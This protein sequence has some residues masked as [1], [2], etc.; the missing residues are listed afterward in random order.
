MTNTI[1]RCCSLVFL[2]ASAAVAAEPIDVGTRLEPVVDDYLIARLDGVA[3]RLHPPIPREIVLKLDRPWEGRY[4]GYF[5]VLTEKGTGPIC[6][7]GPKGAA[8]K[9]DLSPFPAYRMYYRGL[10]NAGRG[11]KPEE[12]TCCAESN[13]GVHWTRPNLGLYE[14]HGTKENNVMLA[15]HQA[16]HNFAPFVDANPAAPADQRYKALGGLSSFESPA[17]CGLV[18]FVSPDGLH[19]RQLRHEPVITRDKSDKRHA[20]DSQNVSFWS[21]SEGCYVCYFRIWA[22]DNRIRWIARTTSRDFVNWSRPE[23][24]ASDGKPL[25]QLYTS[26]LAPTSAPRTSTWGYRRGSCRAAGR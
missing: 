5:T 25:Q 7:N 26:Q 12:V 14:V 15:G 21:E 8:H 17:D 24:L 18:A 13:D 11:T 2:L 23:A 4:C 3:L 20:F 6:R 22:E 1:L 10:P 19:W 9:L 16:C